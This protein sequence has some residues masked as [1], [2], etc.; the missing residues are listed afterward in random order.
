V[1]VE[2]GAVKIYVAPVEEALRKKER[3]GE[4]QKFHPAFLSSELFL[5]GFFESHHDVYDETQGTGA[6][7]GRLLGYLYISMHLFFSWC[8]RN[9]TDETNSKRSSWKET[10]HHKQGGALPIDKMLC[11]Y[12]LC[13]H[14]EHQ[15]IH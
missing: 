4:T 1:A 11:I 15:K 13:P 6:E 5:Q 14:S 7:L 2:V 10:R 8:T 12:L 9:P 3:H